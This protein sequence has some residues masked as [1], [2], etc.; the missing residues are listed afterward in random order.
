MI[1]LRI[2]KPAI[3]RLCT[4]YQL[5][6]GLDTARV[7]EISSTELGRRMGT[8][9]H[10]IRK[11]LSF[12]GEIRSTSTGYLLKDLKER[13]CREFGFNIPRKAC[14]VGLGRLGSAILNYPDFA[15]RGYELAAGFDSSI[16]RLELLHTAVPLY[17]AH[18]IAAVVRRKGIELGVITVPSDAAQLT[19]D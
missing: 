9:A 8:P 18:E 12:L 13:L 6:E 14:I 16:N 10:T 19:A 7:K 5:L 2:S 1:D 17:P 11:D 3:E 4:L 15:L